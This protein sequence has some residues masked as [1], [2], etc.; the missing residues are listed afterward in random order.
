[1]LGIEFISLQ[2]SVNILFASN[3]KERCNLSNKLFFSFL[4]KNKSR[5]FMKFA[6]TK[7]FIMTAQ[8]PDFFSSYSFFFFVY[9]FGF[10]AFHGEEKQRER[11]MITRRSQASLDK[12]ADA[13]MPHPWLHLQCHCCN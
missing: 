12:D 4:G 8:I 13:M 2:N 1:M 6:T 5:V 11:P 7:K 9:F 3:F 10:F